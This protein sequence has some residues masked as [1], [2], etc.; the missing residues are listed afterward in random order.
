MACG[1]VRLKS[2]VKLIHDDMKNTSIRLHETYSSCATYCSN[3][4]SFYMDD[5]NYKYGDVSTNDLSNL[6]MQEFGVKSE[7]VV[8]NV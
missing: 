8:V 1:N 3:Q 4:L 6:V 2:K 7:C 5:T